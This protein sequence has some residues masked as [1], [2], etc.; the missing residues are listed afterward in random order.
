MN[1]GIIAEERNDIE[2]L[3]E[4]TSKLIPV[5]DFSFKKFVAHGCGKLRR[6]CKSWAENLFRRGC[7]HIVV[8]HDLDASLEHE[9]REELTTYVN[10]VG[11][12]AFII[13]IPVHEIEAW[14]LVDSKALRKVFSMKKH[15]KTPMNHESI[16][17]PKKKL[18]EIVWKN[19]KKYYVNTI[20]NQK[21]AK[22]LVLGRIN[23]RCHSFRPYSNFINTIYK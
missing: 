13:L 23:R 6:K 9:L 1:I 4:L 15:P 7:K 16:L 14:L 19:T 5:N 12:D 21:I 18:E 8:L 11:F 20:H 2:V 10:S 22:E 3:Y 17:I